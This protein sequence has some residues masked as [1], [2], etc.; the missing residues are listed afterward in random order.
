M[1]QLFGKLITIAQRIVDALIWASVFVFFLWAMGALYF[2][3]YLPGWLR[4]GLAIAYA[5]AVPVGIWRS[6][7]RARTRAWIAGSIIIIYT[8]TLWVRPSNDRN[9]APDHAQVAEA[10][11]KNGTVT[12][13]HF[14]NCQYRSKS[15]YD[16]I[17]EAKQFPLQN[18]QS[19]WLIVQKF[20]AAEGLAHVFLSFGLKPGQS[21]APD[22]FS[23]SVE[24]RRE[25]GETYS[26]IKGLYR[27]Y[28]ITH[29]IGDERDLIGVRTVYRPDDRVYMYRINATPQQAQQLFANFVE[30]I[31]S[32]HAKP[33]FYH[34]LLNN[35]ANGIT[36]LTYELT[37]EPI[38]WLDYRIVLPG[39]SG[40]FAW[41]SGLV[42]DRASGQTFERLEAASRI[43]GRAQ[44][45]GI[46]E[47]FSQDIRGIQIDQE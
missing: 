19:V 22:Y 3:V 1:Q 7:N 11:I 37:P 35:C 34:T 23:V 10:S 13:N 18:I 42:G 31:Q 24:I 5:I 25:R 16:A 29:V 4:T 12:I 2:L 39:H 20:S 47:T 9:W 27:N 43:D 17:F 41:E 6:S 44:A 30:R 36:G 33:Q 8:A 14:R 45:A 38:N 46:S 28:E 15:D 32:L 26:P 40:Q 21:D